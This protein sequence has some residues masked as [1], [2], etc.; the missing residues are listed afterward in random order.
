MKHVT[1]SLYWL[2]TVLA[3]LLCAGGDLHAQGSSFSF[4][5]V[6]LVQG[7]PNID[8][9]FNNMEQP[10]ITNLGYEYA[11][12]VAP[13]LPVGGGTVN[14]KI[15]PAGTGLA[16]ALVNQDLPVQASYEYVAVAY[17]MGLMPNVKVLERMR[18]DLP[19]GNNAFL[20]V[21]NL[22]SITDPAGFD[23]F[24]DS[25]TSFP[26]FANVGRE[27]VTA[28][29]T[30]KGTSKTLYITPTGSTTPFAQVVVPLVPL[31]RVTL[32]ITGSSTDN[33][34]VYALNGENAE[35]YKLPVL[36]IQG[37]ESGV[38]PSVRVMHAWRQ[39]AVQGSSIQALDVFINSDVQPRG[40]NIRYRTASPKF[41]PFATDSVALRFTPRN[42][43]L[44]TIFAQKLAVVPDTDYTVI[45][46]KT[47]QGAAVTLPLRAPNTF[48]AGVTDSF[49]IRVAQ[50]SDYYPDMSV[51]IMPEGAEPIM[52]QGLQFL[53]ATDWQAIPRGPFTVEAYRQGED[54]AFYDMSY[55]GTM[56][57]T[58]LTLVAL[59]DTSEFQIDLLD[60]M[61][62]DEQVF[63]PSAAVPLMPATD[64]L[65]LR[66]YPNPFADATTIG[67][68]MPRAGHATIVLFDPMGRPVASVLDEEVAAGEQ[69]VSFD[70]SEIPAGVYLYRLEVDGMQAAG[71][72]V[73]TR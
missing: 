38:L 21:L 42:E 22:T 28:F 67:F 40:S 62:P 20:R 5:A 72:M 8:I 55:P 50:V 18:T 11:S 66:N 43:A 61:L 58:Y 52:L 15:A 23:F 17:T 48:P 7:G 29:A 69:S 57:P 54:M 44:S 32:I 9:H 71:R 26:K 10:T 27:A 59:G 37:V 49:Y 46:T 35:A 41:G 3:V 51:K 4:R 63:D 1:S 13:T 6:H 73:V 70:A 14:V 2:L 33:L 34:T 19:G 30:L 31:A 25:T 65:G 60:E 45:L 12:A 64:V 39:K 53:T 47:K 68:S 36:P 16:G 24:I 56:P